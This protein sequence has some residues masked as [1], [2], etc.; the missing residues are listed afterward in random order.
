MASVKI[1]D[2]D[3]TVLLPV[4]W[5]SQSTE[6]V[7]TN[8]K[9]M[10]IWEDTTVTPHPTYLVYKRGTADQVKMGLAAGTTDAN[11]VIAVDTYTILPLIRDVICN[12]ATPFPVYP[13]VATG[14]GVIKNIK[15][16]GAETVTLGN[17]TDTIESELAQY[18][19]T[20]DG[21][22]IKDYA[23]NKWTVF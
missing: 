8:T 14:S 7:L 2:S 15:N 6:P 5:Y 22:T 20:G 10:A 19:V 1:V 12:K 13:P 23:P 3:G 11:F 21:L 4:R 16:I 18:I 9:D 17:V